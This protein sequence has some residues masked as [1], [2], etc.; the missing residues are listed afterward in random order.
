MVYVH[1]SASV[2]VCTCIWR[3]KV[4]AH[5]SLIST[6]M[7]WDRISY[8][9]WSM[10]VGLGWM[11]NELQGFIYL[12]PFPS[13][14]GLQTWAIPGFLHELWVS[15]LSPYFQRWGRNT[16]LNESSPLTLSNGNFYSYRQMHPNWPMSL[17]TVTSDFISQW[18]I[19]EAWR[20]FLWSWVLLNNQSVTIYWDVTRDWS[21]WKI[22]I[23]I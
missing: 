19:R 9:T 10:T 1:A 3:P 8:W 17:R 12:L 22:Q 7:F 20:L 5:L 16:L 18:I 11:A 2:C 4:N 21:L 15:L 14:L 23:P 13:M 6:F